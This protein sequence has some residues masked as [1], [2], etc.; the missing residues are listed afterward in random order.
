MTTEV[1]RLLEDWKAELLYCAPEKLQQW[2]PLSAGGFPD[3]SY[4]HVEKKWKFSAM[5]LDVLKTLF[6]K[7]PGSLLQSVGFQISASTSHKHGATYKPTPEQLALLVHEYAL[8]VQN[9]AVHWT[10]A[11]PKTCV[12]YRGPVNLTSIEGTFDRER[13]IYLYEATSNNQVL[14]PCLS[15]Y[16]ETCRSFSDYVHGYPSKSGLPYL[17]WFEAEGCLGIVLM[18]PEFVPRF[19][20]HIQEV[21][22]TVQVLAR[23]QRSKGNA[24]FFE[25][26]IIWL[27]KS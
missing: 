27:K 9:F 22:L 19:H 7:I 21:D 3:Y 4:D 1:A 10:L 11:T 2:W 23:M 5:P 24:F 17:L 12:W 13:N 20:R 14:P 16:S 8:G 25:P 18:T 6:L 15:D 26:Y